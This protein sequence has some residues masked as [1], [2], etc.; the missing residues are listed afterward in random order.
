MKTINFNIKKAI[1]SAKWAFTTRRVNKGHAYSLIAEL[2]KVV[3]GDLVLAQVKKVNQHKNLQLDV[4]RASELYL[5]D[6]IVVACGDRYAPDQFEAIAELDATGS[7]LVAGG[8]IIGKM[9]YSNQKMNKP[10]EVIPLGLLTNQQGDVI[11][12]ADYALP[13]SSFVPQD[14]NIFCIVGTSMN[15]GKTTAA[16]SLAHGLKKAGHNVAGVKITGTGAYGDYNAFLN[17]GI[18]I[19]ADFTDAGMATTYRQSIDRIE[20]G[21]ASLMA[22]AKNQGATVVVVEIADGLFQ[23][24]TRQLLVDSLVRRHC[25]GVLFACPDAMSAVGGVQLLK[26]MGI[27]PMAVSG[28]ISLSPLACS[29]AEAVSHVTIVSREELRTPEIAQ[30]L[31]VDCLSVDDNLSPLEYGQA[32]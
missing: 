18:S 15:A 17:A 5:H 1:H 25:D 3:S 11:N 2:D 20:S 8:G 9:R 29:E 32:A 28:M 12:I 31:V 16:A 13:T 19:V 23:F 27:Q 21:F 6:Y 10:T 24:E 4:G 7:D 30:S 14:L 22:H 26:T